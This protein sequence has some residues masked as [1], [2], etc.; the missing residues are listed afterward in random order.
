MQHTAGRVHVIA[1]LIEAARER[2]VRPP[3]TV[4]RRFD[5]L[6]AV[7]DDIAKDI[8][9]QLRPSLVADV[10]AIRAGHRSASRVQTRP[11]P[12]VVLLCGWLA[13]GDRAVPDGRRTRRAVRARAYR[14]GQRLQLP[15]PVLPHDSRA[16]PSRWRPIGPARI[17]YRRDARC[18]AHPAGA[19]QIRRRV[20]LGRTEQ[21]FR[22][23]LRL[24]PKDALVH[25]Y[26]SWLL[27]LLGRDDAA[28]R[29][30]GRAGAGALVT[31]GAH[32]PRSDALSRTAIRRCHRALRRVP[33]IRRRLRLALQLRGLCALAN[34]RPREAI[35]DLQQAATL[36]QR[37]PFYLGLLGFCYGKFGM[38]AEA[39]ELVAELEQL[40]PAHLRA[41]AVLR[42][43]LRRSRPA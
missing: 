28:C 6:L 12:L 26:Y 31:S 20:G 24:D 37:S 2:S 39:L 29:G 35:A 8:T 43:H 7:Q 10:R 1:N 9:D 33:P 19:G 13:R 41:V 4:E 36:T 21:E 30:P 27:M 17:G 18:R 32:R 23:A 14:A 40:A 42:L 25:V 34:A 11:A 38:R 5:D 3:L 15:G 16:W 22:R